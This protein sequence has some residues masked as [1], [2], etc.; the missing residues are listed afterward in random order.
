M[1]INRSII[2]CVI[3][4][5]ELDLENKTVNWATNTT[6]DSGK[7]AGYFKSLIVHLCQT[8][9]LRFN[10]GKEQPVSSRTIQQDLHSRR[11]FQMGYK[12]Q[13]HRWREAIFLF[14]FSH[15]SK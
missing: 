13:S 3:H 11:L 5:F 4:H 6:H 12:M 8:L 10:Q 1:G 14:N 7:N 15:N 9:D 2:S